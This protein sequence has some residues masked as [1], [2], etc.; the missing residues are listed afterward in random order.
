MNSEPEIR[1]R[2]CFFGETEICI[3]L[4]MLDVIIELS[5]GVLFWNYHIA[6]TWPLRNCPDYSP[7]PCVSLTRPT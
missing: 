7:T 1:R 4:A 5:V 3:A 6:L 2:N